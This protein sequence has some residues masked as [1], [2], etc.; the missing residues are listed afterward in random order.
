MGK[1]EEDKIKELETKLEDLS[2]FIEN[3]SLPLHWVD[4]NGKIIWANQTELDSLG[5]TKEEYIGHQISEFHADQNIITDILNRLI[6]KETLQNYPATMKCK[7]GSI[8]HVLINS[9]VRW[10]ND[11]FIH[12][13]CFTRDITELKAESEKREK[14]LS[15]LEAKNTELNNYSTRLKA[16]Y[17]DLELKV[18]FRTLELE[19]KINALEK[20]NTDL[21]NNTK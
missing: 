1:T 5:Y 3:A 14:L 18:K 10:K 8:K 4:S 2:D 6:N 20:E 11:T 17:E 21:K 12:T 19:K 16:G 7:D 13:R 15:E 9:N